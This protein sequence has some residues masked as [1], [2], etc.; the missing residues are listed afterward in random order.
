[1]TTLSDI[2]LATLDEVGRVR[3]GVATG[4]SASTLVDSALKGDNKDWNNASAFILYDAGAA[5]AAPEGEVATVTSYVA[6]T[7]TL[8]V[9]FSAAPAASDEYALS[10]PNL[11]FP[12]LKGLVNRAMQRIG[13]VPALDESLS[14]SAGKTEYALPTVAK[15]GR[16]RRVYIS[17]FSDADDSQWKEKLDWYE[18]PGDTNDLV[19][20]SQ[21]ETGQTLRLEY[22]AKPARLRIYSDTISPFIN[23][24]R[25]VA[26]TV[27][28]Y[29]TSDLAVTEGRADTLVD[30][31]RNAVT[32]LERVRKEYRIVDPGF[33]WKPILTRSGTS[34]R[35]KY[36][37]DWSGRP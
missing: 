37:P 26:E 5:G 36:G 18:A 6:N 16:L 30:N 20:R 32:E 28:K 4:G 17:S 14:T 31:V 22:V 19:F 35:S 10:Q 11:S 12:K 24:E 13:D 15:G 3:Y 33:P 8:T 25:I 27:Y 2:I 23:L 34:R 7:G 1:M 21:P 29:F 9:T